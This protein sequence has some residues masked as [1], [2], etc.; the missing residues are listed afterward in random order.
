MVDG[1]ISMMAETP[2]AKRIW[3]SLMASLFGGFVGFASAFPIFETVAPILPK[4]E[5]FLIIGFGG[6][7]EFMIIA[8]LTISAGVI[9]ASYLTSRNR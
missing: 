8:V 4:Q 5:S 1:T 6:L 9:D 2:K 7:L 3:V